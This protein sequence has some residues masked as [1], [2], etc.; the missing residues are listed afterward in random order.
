MYASG[1][2]RAVGLGEH[3]DRLGLGHRLGVTSVEI[4]GW[5]ILLMGDGLGVSR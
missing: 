1:S 4:V 5:G 2:F 3:S